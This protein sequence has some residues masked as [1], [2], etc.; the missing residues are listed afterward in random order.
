[1]SDIQAE[2]L[3]PEEMARQA[4]L[5]PDPG[6]LEEAIRLKGARSAVLDHPITFWKT[7]VYRDSRTLMAFAVNNLVVYA[8]V[9]KNFRSCTLATC[10]KGTRHHDNPN[11]GRVQRALSTATGVRLILIARGQRGQLCDTRVQRWTVRRMAGRD[12]PLA[13]RLP[14][15]HYGQHQA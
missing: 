11:G 14:A 7:G 8:Q 4:V 3:D 5:K 2:A 1:M 13:K 6:L 10:P 15:C 9:S 12:A